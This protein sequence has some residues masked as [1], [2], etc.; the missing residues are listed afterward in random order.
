TFE[1]RVHVFRQLLE[2]VAF[3]HGR[4]IVHR[5]IKPSNVMVGHFGEVFLMDWGIAK[6]LDAAEHPLPRLDASPKPQRVT[7]THTGAAIGPPAHMSPEQARGEKV[8]FRTDTYSLSVLLRDGRH[9]RL[10]SVRLFRGL[11]WLGRRRH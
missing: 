9:Q 5:D 6:P 8:D 3:A 2:A 1:R 10:R 11:R 4:G 7:A